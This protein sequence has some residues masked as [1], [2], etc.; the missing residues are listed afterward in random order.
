MPTIPI[1]WA[2]NTKQL[3]DNLAQ[4][5][6]QIEATK[7]AADKMAKALGGENLIRAAHNYVAAVQQVGGA[8]K[9]TAEWQA[10]V[11]AT[12]TRA[13]EQYKAMG[14]EAPKAMID[15]AN[16]TKSVEKPTAGLMSSLT[17]LTGRAVALGSAVGS[18]FGNLAADG[19]RKIVGG[20]ADVA[21]NGIKL[22]P[23]VG[24]FNALTRAV[25]ET[26]QAMLTSGRTAT[27]GLIGD[28]DLMAA[29]NK[30]L[31]LGL[32]ITSQSFGLLAQTAVVL[33][34][35]MGQ[36]PVKSF[37][38]L[39][40]A[41]GRSSPLILDNLGLSVKVGEANDKYA[42]SVGKTAE[43][44]TQAEQKLAFY[45]SA[46][47][48]AKRK[49]EEVGGLN[50]TLADRV[51]QAKV[52]FTNFTDALGVAIATSPVVNAAFSSI[53]D[54][55]TSAFGENQT[56]LVQRLSR[57]IGDMAIGL[58]TAG[59]VA[60]TVA[61]YISEGFYLVRGVI[62]G[63][64]EAIL[65]VVYTVA[66]VN[67]TIVESMAAIPGA[68]N[69]WKNAAVSARSAADVVGSL[70]ASFKRTKD[71]AFDSMGKTGAAFDK[72]GK[73]IEDMRARMIKAAGAQA[74]SAVIA[75][76]LV[77][78]Q[79]EQT[80]STKKLTAE[81][82]AYNDAL[83][84]VTAKAA[85]YEAV[86]ETIPAFQRE[87]INLLREAGA[88]LEELGTIY[89]LSKV[90][91]WALTEAEKAEKAVTDGLIRSHEQAESAL[92]KL[93]AA[94]RESYEV[95]DQAPDLT[96]KFGRVVSNP[97][98]TDKNPIK[99]GLMAAL[100]DL[101]GIVSQAF[102]SGGGVAEAL[103]ASFARIG[104]AIGKEIGQ[105]F[106][107]LGGKI[108]EVIGEWAG[109]IGEKV[110]DAL[111][112]SAGEDVMHRIGRDWGI[113]ITEA[114]GDQIAE[115]AKTLFGGSRQAAEL[116]NIRAIVTADPENL[117]ITT[118]NIDMVMRKMHDLFSMIETGQMT[119][120]Q[121]AKVIDEN[122]QDMV[123]AGTDAFGFLS[124]GMKELIRLDRQYG[125]NSKEI[126][127]YLKQQAD[128]AVAG[129]NAAIAAMGPLIDAW[130]A[131]RAQGVGAE[132]ELAALAT[133]HRQELEDLGTVALATF[134]A[135]IAAGKSFAEAIELAGPGL[136]QLVEGF[137][138]LG[139]E[140][141]NAA[142][143]ALMLQSQILNA[144]PALVKGVSSLGSAFA[145]LSN[146]GMLNVDTFNA[147]TRTGQQ[148]YARLQGEVA[149]VGGTTRDALLPMQA[150]LHQAQKAAEELGIPLDEN[151][152]RMIDQ[153]KELGIWQ[154]AGKTA[155]EKMLD[156][157]QAL[158][159][160]MDQLLS[161]LFG[162]PSEV[163]TDV[164]IN[165]N[166]RTSGEPPADP[167]STDYYHA[168]LEGTDY[169]HDYQYGAS[170]GRVTSRGLA[171]FSVGRLP[172][173]PRPMGNDIIPGM[174]SPDE[175]IL[176]PSHQAVIGA[177]IARAPQAGS[178]GSTT[179]QFGDIRIEATGADLQDMTRFAP[180]FNEALRGDVGGML[181][182]ISEVSRRAQKRA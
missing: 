64:L 97:L 16:A 104:A 62:F 21:A 144:N 119:I 41:L 153:S 30:G 50:L 88:T 107:K 111:T 169:S 23:T 29:A 146:M 14:K 128:V 33:G 160:K 79:D 68:G 120:A 151:T 52:A 170:G 84:M 65:N 5:L 105:M 164:N 149:K 47:D 115:D 138:A 77:K 34:K 22:A 2:D 127:A 163:N 121:A 159:D 25:G 141:D 157:I 27:K 15:L 118:R 66:K 155:N 123:A 86:L 87:E 137:Q 9:L 40:T 76:Q 56:V 148:M 130:K 143:K 166:Y 82:K 139:I 46:M 38:D 150:Y 53:S 158:V 181:T 6:N 182:A 174:F 129:S 145:A 67:A 20:L 108:G 70:A 35:A 178:G 173:M 152:Q 165:T 24:A 154:E 48:A 13:L 7:T 147:M 89:G 122:W 12:V 26:G 156:G 112:T 42:K 95:L 44:L 80:E 110:Y 142:L 10:K 43:Q 63:V 140:T 171:Y 60:V 45:N 176:T 73:S 49:V 90:Q 74:D 91:V 92:K 57:V 177:L 113:A 32:P 59:S 28:L 168:P 125:T 85:G 8:N 134:A 116:W 114:M 4:G 75:A 135:A 55:I 1:R 11:N 81:Q 180:R 102:A 175:M 117:G 133:A 131:L 172:Q 3:R 54:A 31:L 126:A 98:P 51:Q 132:K 18:F 109:V 78:K 61:K 124:D 69:L 71:E 167:G 58:T 36:G 99:D 39:I 37:D 161:K 93:T 179:V 19:I 136:Q 162:L 72:A 83:A 106:G 103:R 101:P 17:G 94:R 100:D 96:K